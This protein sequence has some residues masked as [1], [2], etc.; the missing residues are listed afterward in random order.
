M[1]GCEGNMYHWFA[2][3]FCGTRWKLWLKQV[4]DDINNNK[5]W[6]STCKAWP[7][8]YIAVVIS[9]TV[10]TS[11][12]ESRMILGCYRFELWFQWQWGAIFVCCIIRDVDISA[13]SPDMGTSRRHMGC[14]VIVMKKLCT[15]QQSIWSGRSLEGKLKFCCTES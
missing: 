6:A 13:T 12:S 8:F 1:R 9:L 5:K 11:A 10:K 7:D 2:G 3:P 15:K 14:Q 4:L